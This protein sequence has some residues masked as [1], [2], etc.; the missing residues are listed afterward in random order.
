MVA[1]Y[2]RKFYNPCG[3]VSGASPPPPRPS[4]IGPQIGKRVFV[5]RILRV[6][7]FRS[8][9]RC[10]VFTRLKEKKIISTS[11][12][13]ITGYPLGPPPNFELEFEREEIATAIF[14]FLFFFL[15]LYFFVS[16]LFSVFLRESKKTR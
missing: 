8:V 5:G 10:V 4:S 12:S 11:R 14:S 7:G 16:P 6:E 13:K 15:R 2:G 9:Y 3:C 1:T